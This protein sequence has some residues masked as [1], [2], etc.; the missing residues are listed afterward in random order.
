MSFFISAK[1][2]CPFIYA[3]TGFFI[4]FTEKVQQAVHQAHRY[5]CSCKPAQDLVVL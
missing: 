3:K 1:Q 5:G 2:L 4:R